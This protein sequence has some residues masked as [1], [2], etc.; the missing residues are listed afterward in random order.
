MLLPLD[1]FREKHVSV[2]LPAEKT[3]KLFRIPWI[4][5]LMLELGSACSSSSPEIHSI[6]NTITI[7][8]LRSPCL[9][10]CENLYCNHQTKQ[11]T[12]LRVITT[13]KMMSWWSW[14]MVTPLLVTKTCR[15]QQHMNA[16]HNKALDICLA[17]CVWFKIW[18]IIPTGDYCFKYYV[19]A[20]RKSKAG[21][22]IYLIMSDH[23]WLLLLG[24]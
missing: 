12:R 22:Y 20:R 8:R 18:P 11:K 1:S 13:T 2:W 17:I 23:D 10:C 14:L 9:H 16:S 6:T 15:E 4:E 24:R 3:H 19:H 21:L 5:R 7:K